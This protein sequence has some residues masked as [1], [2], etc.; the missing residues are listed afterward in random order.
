MHDECVPA[1]K[2]L[3]DGRPYKEVL[4]ELRQKAVLYLNTDGNGRGYLGAGGS[5]SY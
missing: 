1:E 5:H 3:Q 4:A 2:E